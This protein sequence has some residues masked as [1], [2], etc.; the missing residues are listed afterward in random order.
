MYDLESQD[1]E[2]DADTILFEILEEESNNKIEEDWQEN[3]QQNVENRL[4]NK[5]RDDEY[6]LAPDLSIVNVVAVYREEEKNSKPLIIMTRLQTAAMELDEDDNDNG[7]NDESTI[8]DDGFGCG[9]SCGRFWVRCER[10]K[11]VLFETY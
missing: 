7:Y 4:N 8:G 1:Y 6:K 11:M 9:S 3:K 5:A 10:E 2:N